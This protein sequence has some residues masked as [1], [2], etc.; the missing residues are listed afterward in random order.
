M[1]SVTS[2]HPPA[3]C[4]HLV[5]APWPQQ[6]RVDH[7]RA[8]GG[9]HQ[10]DAVPRVHAVH[11]RQ[12][13][14]DHPAKGAQHTA[15]KTQGGRRRELPRTRS[16]KKLELVSTEGTADASAHPRSR[17]PHT[18]SA[19][20]CREAP[21][22]AV[23]GRGVQCA[24]RFR[25]HPLA[26]NSS[27]ARTLYP[28]TPLPSAAPLRRLV[29]FCAP[30]WRQG[31][32]LVEE[33]HA[34]VR[35]AGAGEQLPYGSLALAHVFVE[36]LGA[37]EESIELRAGFIQGLTS[38]TWA[39]RS[40]MLFPALHDE[41]RGRARAPQRQCLHVRCG[42]GLGC[43]AHTL[44]DMKFAPDSL[45]TAL[46]TS[47]LPQPGGPGEGKQHGNTR[48]VCAA[49]H[50]FTLVSGSTNRHDCIWKAE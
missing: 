39:L 41:W 19:Q 37:L 9:G 18:C 8:V 27:C 13:L 2:F 3:P 24:D 12:Q 1:R 4:L 14:V 10:E 20:E 32:Q 21:G 6:R 38:S 44:M 15:R 31:V 47:V 26:S 46:A 35:G 28:L 33:Q 43:A 25:L 23:L 17:A 45:A 22:R 5:Q 40:K 30:P 49:D 42:E 7:V 16:R 48:L 34:G 11:L 36:Q 29:V 50:T